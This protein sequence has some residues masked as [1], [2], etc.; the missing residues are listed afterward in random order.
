MDKKAVGIRL[1]QFAKEKFGS[2][3]ELAEK[4]DMTQASL[5]GTYISGKSLPGAEIITKLILL[6]CDISWLLT[7]KE[8]II[9]DHYTSETYKEIDKRF[10]RIENDINQLKIKNYD[11]MMLCEEKNR[12]IEELNQEIMKLNSEILK[13]NEAIMLLFD[14]LEKSPLA[15]ANLIELR[16]K[17]L[18][19]W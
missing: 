8:N 3:T 18:N 17:F 11:L 13:K 14:E 9:K 10:E 16:R 4:L 15:A 2:V 12:I 1:K 7:G 5:S 19:K 6:G